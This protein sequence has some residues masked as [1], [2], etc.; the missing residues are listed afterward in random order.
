MQCQ[1]LVSPDAARD[2]SRPLQAAGQNSGTEHGPLNCAGSVATGL[3]GRSGGWIDAFGLQC[4]TD[5]DGVISHT[6]NDINAWWELDL[7]RV[8]DI[9]SVVIFNRT[10]CCTE[11]LSDFHLLVSN[12]PFNSK[13]LDSTIAQAGVFNRVVNGAAESQTDLVVSRSGRYLRVQ[14]D[15]GNNPGA[16]HMAEV[17]VFGRG[18]VGTFVIAAG[19]RRT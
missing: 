1:K 18:T 12:Q 17:Q 8:V 19:D 15:S 5:G 4:P 6:Q 7:G 9:D 11:R 3:I 10:D 13:D 2:F 16:L 14:L